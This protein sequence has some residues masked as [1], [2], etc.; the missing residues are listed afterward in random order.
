MELW[1]KQMD[2]W[3]L[4]IDDDEEILEIKFTLEWRLEENR[5]D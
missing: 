5:N 4:R 3:R 2:R 1:N